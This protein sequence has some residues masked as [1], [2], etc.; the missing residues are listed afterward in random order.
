MA[1]LSKQQNKILTH[2][3]FYG[4]ATVREL[5]AYTNYPTSVIRDIKKKGIE[6][7]DRPVKNENYIEYYLEGI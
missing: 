1:K 2:L 7:K 3:I 5:L 4:S 6:I